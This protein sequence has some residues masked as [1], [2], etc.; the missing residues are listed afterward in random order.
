MKPDT[1]LEEVAHHL[2]LQAAKHLV[3][4]PDYIQNAVLRQVRV[5]VVY[6]ETQRYVFDPVAYEGILDAFVATLVPLYTETVKLRQV[7]SELASKAAGQEILI[8]GM[9]RTISEMRAV[10]VEDFGEERT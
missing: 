7:N 3:T 5:V 10:D 9:T 8:E 1:P 2:P 4:V 6:W